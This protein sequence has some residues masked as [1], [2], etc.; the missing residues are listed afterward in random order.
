MEPNPVIE[1]LMDHRSVR[2]F[3]PDPVPEELCR[4]LL[5]PGVRAATAGH[6]QRYAFV[7][8]AD[9]AT[10]EHPD[11]EMASIPRANPVSKFSP[12]V[13]AERSAGVLQNLRHLGLSGDREA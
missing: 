12:S 3:K 6:L 5:R 8:V 9:P 7:V 4:L 13:T 2:K 1:A 11:E 10:I